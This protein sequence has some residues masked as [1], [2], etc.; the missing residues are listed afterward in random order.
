MTQQTSLYRY[1]S[2]DDVL[3]YV[4]IAAHPFKRERQHRRKRDMSL[5]RVVEIEWFDTR[6]DAE[7]AERVAIERERPAWNI[8]ST[9]KPRKPRK[10]PKI[11]IAKKKTQNRKI[12][13]NPKEYMYGPLH[14]YGETIGLAPFG[15]DVAEVNNLHMIRPWDSGPKTMELIK[16]LVRPGSSLWVSPKLPYRDE[17]YDWA[18]NNGIFTVEGARITRGA[19]RECIWQQ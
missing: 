8:V 11:A 13:E 4:G 2:E 6:A 14:P 12:E 7:L 1:F 10:T 16:K 19:N 17:L 9:R 3:L 15:V 18:A 5:V